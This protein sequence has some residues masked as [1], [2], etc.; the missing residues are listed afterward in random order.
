MEITRPAIFDVSLPRIR[1]GFCI[2]AKRHSVPL[3]ADE[4]TIETMQI[5]FLVA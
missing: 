2:N 5:F 3:H 1:F 4:G